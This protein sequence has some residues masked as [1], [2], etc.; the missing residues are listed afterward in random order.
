MRKIFFLLPLLCILFFS[1]ASG[2]VAVDTATAKA[3]ALAAQEQAKASISRS[4]FLRR[5]IRKAEKRCL[6]LLL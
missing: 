2:P 5:N 3:R 6:S 1:C 4:Y